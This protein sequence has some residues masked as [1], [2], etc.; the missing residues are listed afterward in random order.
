MH[1]IE[2]KNLISDSSLGLAKQA[3]WG[4]L[5]S[6]GTFL[7]VVVAV[8]V[9]GRKG[10]R[11]RE[12]RKMMDRQTEASYMAPSC[13]GILLYKLVMRPEHFPPPL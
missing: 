13:I 9:W 6:T 4:W 12:G 3:S 7:L 2:E 1:G 10:W 8:L 11:E 5:C